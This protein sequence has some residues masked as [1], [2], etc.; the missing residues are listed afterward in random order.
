MRTLVIGRGNLGLDIAG[1]YGVE[2]Q[3]YRPFLFDHSTSSSHLQSR[4]E[5]YELVFLCNGGFSIKESAQSVTTAREHLMTSA[6]R[7]REKMH[8]EAKLVCFSSNY[9]AHP[10]LSAYAQIQYDK[11]QALMNFDPVLPTLIVRVANLYGNHFPLKGLPGKLMLQRGRQL[12]LPQNEISPT[13]THW[14]AECMHELIS[15]DL[16]SH[17]R[18]VSLYPADAVPVYQFARRIGV[19]CQQGDWDINWPLHQAD[20]SVG[21]EEILGRSWTGLW[22][23]YG[24]A[25]MRGVG[26]AIQ[27]SEASARASTPRPRT[28]GS[29]TSPR[30]V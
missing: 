26:L 10:A 19:P 17:P 29:Q 27:E 14:V 16:G 13:P 5:G 24:N 21:C 8:P 7:V 22:S 3:E 15:D 1:Q 23:R 12:T 30:V 4:L 18:V 11:E 28:F 9:A 20:W 2:A 25:H 6:M